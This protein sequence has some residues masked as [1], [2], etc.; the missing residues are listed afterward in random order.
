MNKTYIT[1]FKSSFIR[2]KHKTY[3]THTITLSEAASVHCLEVKAKVPTLPIGDCMYTVVQYCFA[4]R[5]ASSS[6]L[7][8]SYEIVYTKKASFKSLIEKNTASGI[9]DTM[10]DLRATLATITGVRSA[11]ASARAD[12]RAPTRETQKFKQVITHEIFAFL[13]QNSHAILALLCFLYLAAER[14]GLVRTDL[15]APSPPN[16]ELCSS[17]DPE[18]EGTC[19]SSSAGS[20]DALRGSRVSEFCSSALLF[21]VSGYVFKFL[22]LACHWV[23]TNASI[24]VLLVLKILRPFFRFSGR[25]ANSTL[26]KKISEPV[27]ETMR[28]MLK[29]LEIK[30]VIPTEASAEMTQEEDNL[31]PG[32]VVPAA[33]EAAMIVSKIAN[34]NHLSP[35]A[36]AEAVKGL[37]DRK[38]AQLVRN[39][40]SVQRV[41]SDPAGSGLVVEEV[42]ENQRYQPFRGW[43]SSWPGH[44]LP[45]DCGKW[46][47][48]VGLPKVGTQSQMFELVAPAL[49]PNW[50]WLETEWQID[51]SCLKEGR[52]DKDGFYYGVMA[53]S[54]LKDFPPASTEAGKKTMK[55]FIRRRRWTRTRIHSQKIREV[56]MGKDSEA[57]LGSSGAS[58]SDDPTSMK[59]K[60]ETLLGWRKPG[61]KP[62]NLDSS[63]T[64]LS[65]D[66]SQL[67]TSGNTGKSQS[68]E[69][70]KKEAEANAALSPKDVQI[71]EI[72]EQEER[73]G[74]HNEWGAPI[75][76]A[77]PTAGG[78]K[79]S[80]ERIDRR[81]PSIFGPSLSSPLSFPRVSILTMIFLDDFSHRTSSGG[82]TGMGACP[83][84]SSRRLL[85]PFPG[86][87]SGLVTGTWT[88]ARNSPRAWT[89]T[90]GPTAKTFGRF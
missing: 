25:V 89:R 53:F 12:R 80:W 84:R 26:V 20:T 88:T 58:D 69:F 49:P 15:A 5:D 81:E 41:D 54:S 83:P 73:I 56:L 31:S 72:F 48:R 78:T 52:V 59:A 24:L 85:P 23:I 51:L 77:G 7:R 35:A 19:D 39:D 8:S 75:P 37:R 38:Q 3:E 60:I 22:V 64:A 16:E 33:A 45:T 10:R 74:S 27:K 9:K 63:W 67:S 30:K 70:A 66:G 18:G 1:G 29:Q 42:F 82:P 34:L 76:Q 44:L 61:K 6:F 87:T 4:R 71:G 43:G 90:A 86:D 65:L 13:M 21:W 68:Q 32:E 62:S 17:I 50:V 46:S 36:Q 55:K 79:V 2:G 57:L 11:P 14:I 28:A 47:D 40:A